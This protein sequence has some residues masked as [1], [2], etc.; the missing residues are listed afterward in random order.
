VHRRK[1]IACLAAL[2]PIIVC[3]GISITGCTRGQEVG[4]VVGAAAIVAAT[5]VII[6]EVN[7]AHHT[8]KGCVTGGAGGYE[9]ATLGDGKVYALSGA[10]GD[11]KVGDILKVHGTK[12][13][14]G[15]DASRPRDFAVEKINHDYGPCSATAATRATP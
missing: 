3:T 8:L 13:R 6:I 15:K 5:T 11:L 4:T 7:N 1:G 9:L 10:T 2:G 14:A 12:H